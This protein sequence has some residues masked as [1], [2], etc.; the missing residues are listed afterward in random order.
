M[1]LPKKAEF[2]R[3]I[4]NAFSKIDKNRYPFIY[5]N[6][7]KDES[8]MELIERIINEIYSR[9]LQPNLEQVFNKIELSL[10]D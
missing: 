7:Q 6:I 4:G 9:S 1:K 2:I 8:R 3:N 5:E 10:A